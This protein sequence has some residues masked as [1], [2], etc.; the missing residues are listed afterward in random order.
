MAEYCKVCGVTLKSSNTVDYRP[1]SCR[2]CELERKKLYSGLTIDFGARKSS[3][4]SEKKTKN[5]KAKG[6]TSKTKV[7]KVSNKKQAKKL[8]LLKLKFKKQ[9]LLK[10]KK[11]K[12]KRLAQQKKLTKLRTQREKKKK[13]L[14]TK[15]EKLRKLRAKKALQLKV[16]KRKQKEKERKAKEKLKQR[17]R[18]AKER[19]RKLLQKERERLK[20]EKEKI[21]N[22]V[23]QEKERIRSEKRTEKERI[24]TE[25]QRV[26][27]EKQQEKERLKKAKEAA[28]LALMQAREA[29]RQAAQEARRLSE[30]AKKPPLVSVVTKV[31]ELPPPPDVKVIAATPK[32]QI[33]RTPQPTK[34]IDPKKPG[35]AGGTNAS[36][37]ESATVIP[38]KANVIEEKEILKQS[39]TAQHNETIQKEVEKLQKDTDPII[40]RYNPYT[41]QTIDPDAPRPPSPTPWLAPSFS[42]V[43]GDFQQTRQ[44]E[45]GEGST[46]GLSEQQVKDIIEKIKTEHKRK[47]T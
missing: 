20:R 5:K 37:L 25:K 11:I 9:K 42:V 16:Q 29:A 32:D 41:Q 1:G 39:S 28:K 47:S 23:R 30:E 14:R 12:A 10:V 6:K 45:E 3:R 44:Q 27:L 34:I 40:D 13:K 31:K 22:I 2:D 43:K 7:R 46:S 4:K 33:A 24:R 35:I 38:A 8:R 19:E 17:I 21:R 36:L 18:K 26:K 15:L